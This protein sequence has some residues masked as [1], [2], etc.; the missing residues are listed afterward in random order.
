MMLYDLAG[1]CEEIWYPRLPTLASSFGGS[2]VLV[3]VRPQQHPM[4]GLITRLRPFALGSGY[5]SERPGTKSARAD[6]LVWQFAVTPESLRIIFEVGRCLDDWA[7]KA[8]PRDLSFLRP[9]GRPWF[10][11]LS[12]E[13]EAQFILSPDEL[14]LVERTLGRALPPGRPKSRP[15]W[16]YPVRD[17]A[18]DP[19]PAPRADHPGGSAS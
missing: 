9:D 13:R 6:M 1:W 3:L 5:E 14:P 15:D 7:T 10:I 17:W 11:S 19:D 2:F 18:P 12:Y 4:P 16:R 8:A